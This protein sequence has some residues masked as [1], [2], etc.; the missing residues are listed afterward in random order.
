MKAL[1]SI[2]LCL[3]NLLLYGQESQTYTKPIEFNHQYGISYFNE[4]YYFLQFKST[5]NHTSKNNLN[6]NQYLSKSGLLS[7][8]NNIS[9]ELNANKNL[10]GNWFGGIIPMI[11]INPEFATWAL[12]PY[13]VH[14]GKIHDIQFIKEV[15]LNFTQEKQK[16]IFAT[17]TGQTTQINSQTNVIFDFGLA[18][19]YKF[20]TQKMPLRIMISGKAYIVNELTDEDSKI[21]NKRFFDFSSLK[22]NINTL[23]LKKINVGIFAMAYNKYL[24]SLATSKKPE[25]NTTYFTPILG[26]EMNYFLGKPNSN[27]NYSYIF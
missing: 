10:N 22:L 27:G 11:N 20:N 12:K 16:Q 6:S 17:S 4:D 18:L 7:G 14:N 25:M 1:F 3:I 23:I 21:Y 2:F 19:A 9:F 8:L 15:G 5:L 13:V 26:W 24:I